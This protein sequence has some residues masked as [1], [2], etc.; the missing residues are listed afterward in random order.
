MRT[1]KLILLAGMLAG[2]GI[3][4][5]QTS[6]PATQ[7]AKITEKDA[8]DALQIFISLYAD[9][10][11][12][13]AISPDKKDDIEVAGKLLNAARASKTQPALVW[14]LCGKCYELAS[15]LIDGYL[16]AAEAMQVAIDN[17]PEKKAEAIENLLVVLYKQINMLPGDKRKELAD[18]FAQMSLTLSDLR[19]A[20][21]DFDGAVKVIQKAQATAGTN[22]PLAGELKSRVESLIERQ[23][24]SRQTEQLM[25]AVK[26]DPKDANARNQ[27]VTFLVVELNQPGKAV[28]FLTDAADE[29]ARALVPLAAKKI[30]DVAETDLSMLADWYRQL[31]SKTSSQTGKINTLTRAK[32][33]YDLFLV[34]HTADD[35]AKTTATLAG[36]QVETELAKIAPQNAVKPASATSLKGVKVLV[37]ASST[38]L[39]GDLAPVQKHLS[40]VGVV[41]TVAS[42]Q[43]FAPEQLKQVK[44]VLIVDYNGRDANAVQKLAEFIALSPVPCVVTSSRLYSSAQFFKQLEAKLDKGD[45]LLIKD[46]RHPLAAGLSKTVKVTSETMDMQWMKPCDPAIPVAFLGDDQGKA[47]ILAVEKGAKPTADKKDGAA[48]GPAPAPARRVIF[49]LG[50]PTPIYPKFT[51]EAWKLFDAAILWSIGGR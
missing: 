26:A 43:N 16:V 47:V 40:D 35:L 8:Q 15:V 14:L 34:K 49:F 46:P 44:A 29:K 25:A 22:S 10:F 51:P 6:A 3:C 11:R 48:W 23:K 50:R 20:S 5:A 9:D 1:I 33:Y 41:F 39:D 36:K 27:L 28:E 30:E 42:S 32:E 38:T 4:P 18:C 19:V 31:S 45:S 13:A 21:D 17:V 2:W 12:T 7:V 24:L 37:V